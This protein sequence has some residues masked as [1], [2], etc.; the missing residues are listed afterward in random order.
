MKK[1]NFYM[2]VLADGSLIDKR[3]RADGQRLLWL[4]ALGD[5]AELLGVVLRYSYKHSKNR[6]GHTLFLKGEGGDFTCTHSNALI[7]FFSLA[8]R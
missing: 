6:V 4:R 2:Q 5:L 3:D 8:R 1:G 7:L